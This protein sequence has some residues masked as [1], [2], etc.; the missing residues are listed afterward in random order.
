[1]ATGHIQAGQPHGGR[2]FAIGLVVGVLFVLLTT[3]AGLYELGYL[4][5]EPT[6]AL[7]AR[8]ATAQDAAEA[9]PTPAWRFRSEWLTP[10]PR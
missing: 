7:E 9:R 10:H 3:L 1:M 4:S 5:R 8:P 2:Q 6:E